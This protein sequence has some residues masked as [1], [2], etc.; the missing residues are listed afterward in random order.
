LL[1]DAK[2]IR[3]A[4]TSIADTRVARCADSLEDA[5]SRAD[6]AAARESLIHLEQEVR[7]LSESVLTEKLI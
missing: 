5:A 1:E 6:L 4:A 3:G 2:R 7:R